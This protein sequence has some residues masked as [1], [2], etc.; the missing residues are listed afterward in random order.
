MPVNT[1]T[2]LHN[3]ENPAT[4]FTSCLLLE[5]LK[6]MQKWF[7]S[8]APKF[9]DVRKFPPNPGVTANCRGAIRMRLTLPLTHATLQFSCNHAFE[10]FDYKKCFFAHKLSIFFRVQTVKSF[11]CMVIKTQVQHHHFFAFW[12]L[13]G[14]LRVQTNAWFKRLQQVSQGS[15]LPTFLISSWTFFNPTFFCLLRSHWNAG[16]STEC[17]QIS[18]R[19]CNKTSTTTRETTTTTTETFSPKNSLTMPFRSFLSMHLKVHRENP[20]N[21]G[22]QS[23]S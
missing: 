3:R 8:L 11:K 1:P 6:P 12:S 16:E 7:R 10:R 19:I 2:R 18:Q 23:A 9:A 5:K 17:T 21:C 13:K 22:T 15:G 20:R 14:F 4:P